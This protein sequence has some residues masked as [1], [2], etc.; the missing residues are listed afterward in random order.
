MSRAGARVADEHRRPDD[1]FN[2]L[3]T[4]W[5]IVGTRLEERDLVADFGPTYRE[6]QASVPMLIPSPRAVLGRRQ[7]RS[8]D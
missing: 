2:V 8:A 3:W 6:F 1:L 4:A 7:S 5:I